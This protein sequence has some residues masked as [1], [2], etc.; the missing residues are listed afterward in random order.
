MRHLK[1]TYAQNS[2]E[3]FKSFMQGVDFWN[4]GDT[5]YFLNDNIPLEGKT[6]TDKKGNKHIK[7]EK[8]APWRFS[9][10]V[11]SKYSGTEIYRW[12]TDD[13][14][15]DEAIDFFFYLFSEDPLK[16]HITNMVRFC[17]P[18]IYNI[19]RNASQFEDLLNKGEYI[20]K[21]IATTFG[22][23]ATPS[24]KNTTTPTYNDW[25]RAIEKNLEKDYRYFTTALDVARITRNRETAH[26]II[27]NP[28]KWAL[29]LLF[30]LHCHIGTCLLLIHKYGIPKDLETQFNKFRRDR[31]VINTS[32]NA[33]VSLDRP[34]TYSDTKATNRREVLLPL[35]ESREYQL[36][37]KLNEGNMFDL[38]VTIPGNWGEDICINIDCKAKIADVK[39]GS[40]FDCRDTGSS[41]IEDTSSPEIES[42]TTEKEEINVSTIGRIPAHTRATVGDPIN[43]T[44]TQSKTNTTLITLLLGIIAIIAIVLL[45][46]K[47]QSIEQNVTVIT[48]KEQVEKSKDNEEKSSDNPVS[49]GKPENPGVQ[50]QEVSNGGTTPRPTPAKPTP[51]PQP[52]VDANYEAGMA[53]Y[54][55]GEG[56]EAI[57]RFQASGSAEAYYMLGTIY[58]RGLGSI[59]A[60]QMKARDYYKKAKNLGSEK[61][62][63]KL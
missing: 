31:V 33:I 51:K 56:L 22:I 28:N 14:K 6:Y 11:I 12:L 40:D 32:E 57:K 49:I 62:K 34:I 53:A 24:G 37:I 7:G 23:T 41:P 3:G 63:A 48:G 58:E 36:K 13:S 1:N 39:V 59:A 47:G 42:P 29:T 35:F 25:I 55:A 19:T 61:A 27:N 54:N 60:N 52:K 46:G 2:F 15:L 44:H 45:L 8:K 9:F 5:Y 20:S 30:L 17:Y 10:R 21:K 38:K 18:G 50:P 43:N 16:D 4:S 26:N